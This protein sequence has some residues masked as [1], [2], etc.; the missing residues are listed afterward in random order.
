MRI[1]WSVAV[2]ALVAFAT[3]AHADTLYL[4]DGRT[5]WGPEI[6]EEGDHVVVRRSGQTLRFPKA[7]V[8]R[9]ERAR[10]SVP[11]YVDPPADAA[12]VAQE[13]VDRAPSATGTGAPALHVPPPGPA[14][15]A[16][17]PPQ[18]APAGQPAPTRIPAPP[19]PA[20]SAPR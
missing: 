9:I 18:A 7:E 13:G 11:R 10:V 20:M 15:G 14:P 2:A 19:P 8:I 3:H 12:P 6:D 16:A 17:A 4:K 1:V 5:V